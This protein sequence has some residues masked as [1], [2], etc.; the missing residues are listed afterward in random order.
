MVRPSRASRAAPAA[1][2][3]QSSASAGRSI[4][5]FGRVT[6]RV[7]PSSLKKTAVAT[8]APS[9]TA[10][11]TTPIRRHA[12]ERFFAEKKKA[13]E[14]KEEKAKKEQKGQRAAEEAKAAAAKEADKTK[15]AVQPAGCSRQRKRRAA[16]AIDTDSDSLSNAPLA[17]ANLAKRARRTKTSIADLLSKASQRKAADEGN[18]AASSFSSDGEIS[19]GDLIARLNINASF[20]ATPSLS[21]PRSTSSSPRP[22]STAPTSPCLSESKCDGQNENDSGAV[23]LPAELLDLVRL[24]AAFAKTLALHHAHHGTNAPVDVRAFCPTVAQSWGKRQVTLEDLQRCLGVAAMTATSPTT[25]KSLPSA[26]FLSDYGRGK[27]CIELQPDAVSGAG[28]PFGSSSVLADQVS[29]AFEANLRAAWTDWAHSSAAN[30]T[31]VKA[32]VESLPKAP[33]TTCASLLQTSALRAKGQ[34]S[35]EELMRGIALKKQQEQ[36]AKEALRRPP[37]AAVQDNMDVNSSAAPPPPMNLLDRI[38]LR[39]LQRAAAGASTALP[40]HEELERRAALHRA[41]DIAEVLAMLCT[42]TTG[43]AGNTGGGSRRRVSLGMTAIVMKI[44]D[45]LRLPIA[46]EEAAACVR[47]L[48]REVAPQWLQMVS[49]GGREIV[50]M[51]ADSVPSKTAIQGRVQSLIE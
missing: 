41:G 16:E 27:I 28:N 30:A 26:L 10:G 36:E 29:T 47:L 5:S 13:Q 11:T 15:D 19:T 43:S 51:M 23:P 32:F 4:D 3:L 38:R 17:T 45:S 31:A 39:Q 22:A 6:K 7:A 40:T 44:K 37:V 46:R 9:A 33:I 25:T 2:K 50:I 8:T 21:P 49:L 42:A 24:Q 18:L 35:L 20:S 34:R 12:V 48:A 14:E 1:T